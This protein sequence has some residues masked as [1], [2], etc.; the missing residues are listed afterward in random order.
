MTS[1]VIAFVQS[2]ID[3]ARVLQ[4]AGTD[5]KNGLWCGG[6]Y[7]GDGWNI[8]ERQGINQGLTVTIF[9]LRSL[10]RNLFVTEQRLD[11]FSN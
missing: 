7:E 1:H 9:L 2:L 6:P 11:L 8:I 5:C 4:T 3:I 10:F